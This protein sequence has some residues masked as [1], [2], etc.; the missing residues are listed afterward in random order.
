MDVARPPYMYALLL[1]PLPVCRM[2]NRMS[3][4]TRSI[5]HSSS[6]LRKLAC[7]MWN[8]FSELCSSWPV[9]GVTQAATAIMASSNGGEVLRTWKRGL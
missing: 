9:G 3:A 2:L 5:R 7:A 8:S 1:S 4:C 6:Q